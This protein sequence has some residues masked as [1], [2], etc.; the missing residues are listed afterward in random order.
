MSDDVVELGIDDLTDAVVVGE[1]GFG[2]VYKA[3]Q[4]SLRRDVAVKVVTNTVKDRKVRIRF[5]REI[6]AM[7]MLSGHPNI[8][9]VYDSGFTE[10][11]KPYIL[12]DFMER[13]SL[14]DR[15]EKTGAIPPAEVLTM[16]VKVCGALETAHQ[17]GILHRDLKPENILV[18]GYGEPKLGD[19]GIARLKGGPETQTSSLTASIEH[20]APELLEAKPPDAATDLYALGSTMYK[21]LIGEAA[22]VHSTDQSIVPALSRIKDDPV[23][24]LRAKGIPDDV[25]AL[26]ERAM[27]KRQDQRFGSAAQMGHAIRDAQTRM[28]HPVT[29][30][31]VREDEAAAVRESTRTIHSDDIA[32]SIEGISALRAGADQRGTTDIGPKGQ[33]PQH[34]PPQPS[35]PP[36]DQA[37]PPGWSAAGAGTRPPGPGTPTSPGAQGP[38]PHQPAAVQPRQHQP[39]YASGPAGYVPQQ[40]AFGNRTAQPPPPAQSSALPKILAGVG[41]VAIVIIGGLFFLAGGDDEPDDD[42]TPVV[43]GDP[44]PPEVTTAPE[45]TT[46][47]A[48][49]T[50][51]AAPLM[52]AETRDPDPVTEEPTAE[53]APEYAAFERLRDDTDAITVDVP[54][55]WSDVNGGPWIINDE[56]VGQQIE[57]STDLERFRTTWA[58]PGVIFGVSEQL[59]ANLDPNAVL[60]ALDF[61]NQCEYTG[62]TPY[63]DQAY[64]GFRDDYINCGA[65]D[66]DYVIVAAEPP[67][68][69]TILLV[70]FQGLEPRDDAALQTVLDTFFI[71]PEAT[72]TPTP[73]PTPSQ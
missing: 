68:Q 5:E 64:T 54:R 15:L 37:P 22:F 21:L 59:R 63:E 14:G 72:P 35:P 32:R 50:T 52:P 53:P 17:A 28:G 16:M 56:P 3:R 62:R 25:A 55:P 20:V 23:P 11:G 27:A 51:P 49:Q 9:T 66:A 58:E 29:P 46:P 39:Q 33:P 44:T 12:M 13:G 43:A 30:L 47:P 65:T 69:D 10:Q 70:Q 2:T 38:G 57:A 8:V 31:P 67:E 41:A 24:D 19:F 1:G 34:A 45:V 61:S 71:L 42:P 60:D 73:S 26:V 48:T 4:E 18:S 7:G 40:G 36:A 6:Q